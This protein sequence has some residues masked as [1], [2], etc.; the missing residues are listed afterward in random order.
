MT[1]MLGVHT[2]TDGV[3]ALMQVLQENGTSFTA[4]PFD[5]RRKDLKDKF[6]AQR[7]Y[8]AESWVLSLSPD[9]FD[10]YTD[11]SSLPFKPDGGLLDKKVKELV[12]CAIDVA[13]FHL[14]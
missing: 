3:P 8:C 7:G 14:Y 5:T 1:G 11:F 4:A 9:F 12:Y 2:L 6:T 13:T 10:A